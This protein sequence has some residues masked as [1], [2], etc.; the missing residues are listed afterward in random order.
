M[1]AKLS[2]SPETFKAMPK[3]TKTE[4]IYEFLL[5]ADINKELNSIL[6][7]FAASVAI[8]ALL[9]NDTS[10]MYYIKVLD[11]AYMKDKFVLIFK[12][13]SSKY[14]ETI[15]LDSTKLIISLAIDATVEYYK[16]ELK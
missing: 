8:V 7:I 13:V 15:N 11:N 6:N 10:Y 3:T 12:E 1:G 9:H 2:I 5:M 16:E 4:F 14:G